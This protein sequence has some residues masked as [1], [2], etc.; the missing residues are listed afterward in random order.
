MCRP[1]GKFGPS[2]SIFECQFDA[3]R[4]F[5]KRRGAMPIAALVTP[6]LHA[7]ARVL[8]FVAQIVGRRPSLLHGNIRGEHIT[9][10]VDDLDRGREICGPFELAA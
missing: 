9:D 6:A 10:A 4:R 7:G 1:Q 5:P 3:I 2:I 8:D